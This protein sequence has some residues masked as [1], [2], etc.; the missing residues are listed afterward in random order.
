MAA[1]VGSKPVPGPTDG[2]FHGKEVQYS[3]QIGLVGPGG[4]SGTWYVLVQELYLMW[5]QYKRR[6]GLVYGGKS[7]CKLIWQQ[8]RFGK[9]GGGRRE[10]CHGGGEW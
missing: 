9:T 6:V 10:R 3:N 5:N 2:P 4:I 8:R 1:I 7:G